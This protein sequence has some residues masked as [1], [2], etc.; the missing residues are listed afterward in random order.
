MYFLE[1]NDA[2]FARILIN[3]LHKFSAFM[4]SVA[5]WET[6]TFDPSNLTKDAMKA[7][8]YYTA[9]LFSVL[10]SKVNDSEFLDALNAI[11]SK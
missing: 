7:G 5:A 2:S 1:P 10:D 6:L 11:Q 3:E 9:I 8:D 4:S